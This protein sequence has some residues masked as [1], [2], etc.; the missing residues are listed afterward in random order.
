MKRE[1]ILAVLLLVFTA[2]MVQARPG[3]RGG[4]VWGP[5]VFDGYHLLDSLKIQRVFP[6]DSAYNWL[7]KATFQ[8]QLSR[9]A[10][11]HYIVFHPDSV[12]YLAHKLPDPPAKYFAPLDPQ[13]AKF[14]IT[15][16]EAKPKVAE[17]IKIDVGRR[18][19]VKVFNSSMQFSQAYISPNWYQ[20]G[21]NN[22]N[23][24][25]QVYYDVKLNQAFHPNWL[26]QTTMQYKLGFNNAPDDSIRNYNIS[27]DLLQIN[28]MAG[29]K[30]A[31]RWYY[32]TN[33]MFK[34][35]LLNSYKSNTHDLKSSF[36]SPGELNLGLGMTYNYYN[37]PKTFT[38]DLA[39]SPMSWNMKTCTSD[40]IDPANFGI[41]S[42]RRVKNE[43]G[44]NLEGKLSWKMHKNVRLVSRLFAFTNYT[45]IQGDWENTLMMNVTKYLTTQVYVHLR[46]DSQT[47]YVRDSDWHKLQLKEIFSFGVAYNF[48]SI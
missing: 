3:C 13:S 39:L 44:S 9:Q 7:E 26:F 18:H 28:M 14:E 45:Y 25:L 2:M 21:S 6:E 5:T 41:S 17:D 33:A 48:S 12:K 47:P 40:R 1:K 35:Q 22:L 15:K 29:Y 10:R 8:Q 34:T 27:E 11:Q 37:K 16:I 23:T 24:L 19:W 4:Q 42:D 32:S 31:H 36:L 38:F 30:A 46:Y 43:F 20:G